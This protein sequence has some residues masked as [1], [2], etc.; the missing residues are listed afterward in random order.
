M[1]KTISLMIGLMCLLLVSP[2]LSQPPVES[3]DKP[4]S[5]S[6]DRADRSQRNPS[7]GKRPGKGGPRIAKPRISD[8]IK[9]TVYADNWCAVYINGK[10]TIV[11][12]I[13]FIPHN[14]VSVDILPEYPM[15]IAVLARDNADPKTG[16][17][18]SNTNIGD[19]GFI[20]KFG[21]GTVSSAKWKAK[22]FFHGPLKGDLKNPKVEHTDLPEGWQLPGFDDSD[23]GKA[24]EHTEEAVGPKGPF[25]EHDFKGA[26]WIWTADLALDNTILFR[27]AIPAPPNGS[28]VPR[29]WPRGTIDAVNQAAGTP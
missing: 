21:D 16:L 23:W 17:E 22:S 3:P 25:Y 29:E 12:S 8:T 28:A 1:K 20:L 10:L 13:S 15:T 9:A 7:P 5:K 6:P 2:T 4:S 19:G 26:A 18:Y 11:D 27:T 14:V 24:V